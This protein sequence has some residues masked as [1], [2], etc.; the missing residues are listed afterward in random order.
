MITIKLLNALAPGEFISMLGGIYEHSEWVAELAYEQAPFQGLRELR[1]AM[2][3]IVDRASEA[4]IL[5]LIR[6]HPDLAGKLA[7]SGALTEASTREQSGLGLD[8]LSDAEFEIFSARN[9]AYREHFGFPF[10]I[11]ARRTTKQGVLDAF[12]ERLNNSREREI[13]AALEQIHQI[14]ELRL[15][16][17][18]QP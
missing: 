5:A 6:A 14:A 18:I 3:T 8:R 12:E 10:I 7:R 17:Q 11:C 4:E 2:R 1:E 16:D 9:S 15:G 13:S